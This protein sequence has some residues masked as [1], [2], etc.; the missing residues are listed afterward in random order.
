MRFTCVD[1][2]QKAESQNFDATFLTTCDRK[3]IISY[4]F[5]TQTVKNLPT[6]QET[7]V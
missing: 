1:T 5:L 3:A 6:M 2:E 7:W 4:G